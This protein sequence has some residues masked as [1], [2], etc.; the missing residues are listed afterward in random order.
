L[1]DA[2]HL[3]GQLG[4]QDRGGIGEEHAA[5]GRQAAVVARPHARKIAIVAL[6][7]RVVDVVAG[8]LDELMKLAYEH[9]AKQ[10]GW[11]VGSKQK[12]KRVEMEV[13]RRSQPL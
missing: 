3:L 10:P 12:D 5:A 1:C 8:E 2:P 6:L 13:V 11:S 4:W 9:E 7:E